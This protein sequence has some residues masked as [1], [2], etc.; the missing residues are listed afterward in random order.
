MSYEKKF[1][2]R[3]VMVLFVL[4][5]SYTI[6]TMWASAVENDG[7][8]YYDEYDYYEYW[9]DEDDEPTQVL[10]A[11]AVFKIN[12]ITQTHF[13]Q[14]EINFNTLAGASRYMP[15]LTRSDGGAV[16]S[17]LLAT[18]SPATA[19]GCKPG[20]YQMWLQALNSSGN[21]IATSPTKSVTFVAYTVP[22]GVQAT[23]TSGYVVTL[24]WLERDVFY[25]PINP[26]PASY[27][28]YERVGN[29]WTYINT[30]SGSTHSVTIAKTSSGTYYFAVTQ[31]T[32]GN[33]SAKSAVV[34]V[35]I[36]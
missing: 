6:L 26:I 20:T 35:T 9:Y 30:V 33:E 29:N 10:P 13:G 22:Q 16:A 31:I 15:C 4:L 25:G 34:S 21:V 5:T 11:S 2:V 23:N 1:G 17:Q 27:K 7:L 28:I 36:P 18:S 3:L 24:S 8:A 14:A 12:T 19:I 32:G